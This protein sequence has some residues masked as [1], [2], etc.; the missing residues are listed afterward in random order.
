MITSFP[1]IYDSRFLIYP[2]SYYSL[3]L[4]LTLYQPTKILDRPKLK[5]FAD[6][7]KC[8]S[9]IEIYIGRIETIVEKE[10]NAGYQP[11][12]KAVTGAV[13]K[14]LTLSLSETRLKILYNLYPETTP[15]K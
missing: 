5:A 3:F 9:K 13:N 1:Y 14:T 8:D 6:D 7:M 11:K 2:L 4:N 10:E 15:G 12:A